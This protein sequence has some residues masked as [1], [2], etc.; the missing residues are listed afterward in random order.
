[1]R[2][3]HLTAGAGTRYCGACLRDSAL[4]RALREA[5]H[6]VLLQPLYLPI[7]DEG[8]GEEGSTQPIRMGGIE[9]WLAVHTPLLG[10]LAAAMGGALSSRAALRVA[11]ALGDMTDPSA[12]GPMTEATL[13]VESG[14]LRALLE[15]VAREVEA[16]SPD[17][18]IL[19]NA[20]LLGLAPVLRETTNATV[21]CTLQ[22]EVSFIE[23]L[24]EPW[25]ERVWEAL[26]SLTWS[27]HGFVAVSR[28]HGAEMAAR[29]DL[30]LEDI[31][32]VPH[33][34]QADTFTPLEA[35]NRHRRVAYVA[36]IDERHGAHR[37]LK[38]FGDLPLGDVPPTL[39]VAGSLTAQDRPYLA[40][41]KSLVQELE[42]EDRV[43]F[44]PNCTPAEKRALL[45]ESGVLCVPTSREAAGRYV[46]EAWSSGCAVLAPRVGSLVEWLEESGGGVLYDPDLEGGLSTALRALCEDELEV[47]A[48]AKKGE[49]AVQER[50]SDG[51]MAQGMLQAL[52]S[53]MQPEHRTATDRP[54]AEEA[55]A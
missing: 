39:H 34:V 7:H 18:V 26:K 36:R 40:R 21:V 15:R 45:G 30:P 43:T 3:V 14:A 38:A 4:V 12:L 53:I 8:A 23:D 22:S 37:L 20:L 19:S 35:P 52:R 29:L 49:S 50:Y 44:S 13:R 16:Y 55:H 27:A 48:L 10:R 54:R 2:I 5:G 51:H 17:V 24:Q 41:L 9:T 11:S 1:M 32:V 33:G 31:F 25:P 6:D 42:I 28:A 46:L 47:A